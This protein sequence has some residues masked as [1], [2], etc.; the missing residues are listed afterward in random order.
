MLRMRAERP[1]PETLWCLGSS[2]VKGQSTRRNEETRVEEI[3][4]NT[5]IGSFC[6]RETQWDP[7]AKADLQVAVALQEVRDPGGN[8]KLML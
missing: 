4:E 6:C 5:N 3:E 1:P 7:V 8:S 2:L